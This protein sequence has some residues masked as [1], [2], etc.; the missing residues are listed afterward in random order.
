MGKSF[1]SD[2]ECLRFFS[3]F[4][5]KYWELVMTACTRALRTPKQSMTRDLLVPP[6][7]GWCQMTVTEPLPA[8][9]KGWA[10]L[11]DAICVWVDQGA[12]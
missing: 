11:R 1:L 5:L 6:G 7:V 10:W 8:K 12:M 4:C 9:G 3:L 2:R